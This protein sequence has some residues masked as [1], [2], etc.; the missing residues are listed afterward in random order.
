MDASWRDSLQGLKDGLPSTSLRNVDAVLR[1]L[2]LEKEKYGPHQEQKP[3]EVIPPK[4]L[5]AE[6]DE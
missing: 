6:K 5:C 1:R 2:L 4:L 3:D